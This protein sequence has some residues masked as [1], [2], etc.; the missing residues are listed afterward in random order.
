MADGL[1]NI[2]VLQVHRCGLD[3]KFAEWDSG[4]VGGVVAVAVAVVTLLGCRSWSGCERVAVA[5]A[6][7]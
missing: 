5:A 7:G 1:A 4:R 6:V 2:F 3:C